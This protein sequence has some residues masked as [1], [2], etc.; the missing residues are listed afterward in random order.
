MMSMQVLD[1]I[2]NCMLAVA[3]DVVDDPSAL[4]TCSQLLNHMRWCDVVF[5]P[6]HLQNL[7]L[8]AVQVK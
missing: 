1:A 7:L 3:P 6:E 4:N 5:D 2:V 8:Q